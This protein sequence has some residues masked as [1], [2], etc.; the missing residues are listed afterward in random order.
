MKTLQIKTAQ[1]VNINFTVATIGQRLSAFLL[2]NIMK[3]TYLLVVYYVF[4]FQAVE[5]LFSGDN[6]TVQA[7]GILVLVPVTFYSLYTEIF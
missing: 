4:D 5:R 1:N 2:D 3:L 6:W 7:V